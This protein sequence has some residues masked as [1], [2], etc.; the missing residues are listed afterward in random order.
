MTISL[1]ESGMTLFPGTG[2]ANEVGP[3][4]LAAGT[5]VNIAMPEST[6]D[7]GWLRAF[8]AVVPSL[9]RQ[10]QPEVIVSQHGCDSHLADDMSH[11][12]ISINGQREIAAHISLLADEPL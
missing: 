5:S 9:L 12:N 7:S 1:H 11:L 10:F 4:G 3:E 8:D 6:T 2:F